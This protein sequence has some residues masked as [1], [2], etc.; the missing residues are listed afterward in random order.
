MAQDRPKT[1]QDRPKKVQ[2]MLKT[3]LRWSM[4]GPRQ[5][6]DRAFNQ[7]I[8]IEQQLIPLRAVSRGPL[9]KGA[10]KATRRN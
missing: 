10:I 2:D 3:G 1:A 7:D 6:Q 5:A 4:T 9:Y 8:R